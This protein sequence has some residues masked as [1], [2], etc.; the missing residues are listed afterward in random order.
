VAPKAKIVNEGQMK[1]SSLE[2][3][4]VLDAL[5]NEKPLPDFSS[6]DVSRARKLARSVQTATVSELAQLP[7]ALAGAILEASIQARDPRLADELAN[8]GVKTLVKAAKK[9]L[10][11]LRSLGVQIPERRG[12]ASPP[13]AAESIE[14]LPCLLSPITGWG[15]QAL[16]GTLHLRGGGLELTQVILS[17]ERGL[18][19]LGQ[20]QLS[21][22]DYRRQ[23]KEIR[24]RSGPPV[25]EIELDE[26]RAILSHA[27]ALNLKSKTPYPPGAEEFLRHMGASPREKPMELPQPNSDDER[28]A[29]EGQRLFEEPEMRSWLPPEN[30]LRVLGQKMDEVQHSPL[31]LTE[32]QR[33]EQLLHYFRAAAKTFFTLERR[34]LYAGRLWH[35]AKLFEQTQ[36]AQSAQVAA[37]LARQLFH[38]ET[39]TPPRFCELLY[40]RVLSLAREAQQGDSESPKPSV[41][42]APNAAPPERRS[43]GGL[44]L[45]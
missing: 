24:S 4:T 33:S 15:E 35:M 25:R 19:Q 39:E 38:S 30:E 3:R 11:R 31:Q 14:E 5:L 13:P 43:P 26:A 32:A 41:P 20:R 7:E 21:R 17:D 12:E 18:I 28:L 34:K 29:T 6:D 23:L 2:P 40:E 22:G 42:L 45:P 44:I 1:S 16:V 9:T 27:A 10:Y 36:R 8:L 37:A